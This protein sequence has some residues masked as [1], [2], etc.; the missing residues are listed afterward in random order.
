MSE[1]KKKK[2][3][4]RSELAISPIFTEPAKKKKKVSHTVASFDDM[5]ALSNG[6]DEMIVSPPMDMVYCFFVDATVRCG[7]LIVLTNLFL[8]FSSHT[9]RRTGILPRSV[10]HVQNQP[11]RSEYVASKH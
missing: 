7:C 10:N 9:E 2:K 6:F 4:K 5:Q 11:K 3:E 8:C 1:K